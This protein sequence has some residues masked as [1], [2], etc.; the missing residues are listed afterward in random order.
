MDKPRV[1][2]R[3][4]RIWLL[5][6]KWSGRKPL[7]AKSGGV[8]RSKE[9]ALARRRLL[10]RRWGDHLERATIHFTETEWQEYTEWMDPDLRLDLPDK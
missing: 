8:F 5:A 2:P 10:A 9:D 3:P 7:G 1:Q 4:E 6:V